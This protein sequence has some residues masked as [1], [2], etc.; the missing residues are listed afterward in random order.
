[1]PD[2]SGWVQ[3]LR[4]FSNE[5]R[6]G[7][8]AA[9]GIYFQIDVTPPLDDDKLKALEEECDG[10]LPPPLREFLNTGASSLTF[11]WFTPNANEPDFEVAFCPAEELAVWRQECI[12]YA[13]ESW[14]T[15]PEW[16]LDY[17]LWRHGW[18]LTHNEAGDGLAIW[19]H[20]RRQPHHP[21]TYLDHEGE[22]FLIAPT[23]D[24]FL[25]HWERLGYLDL[26]DLLEFRDP[27][28]G[29]LNAAVQK[30]T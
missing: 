6:V 10:Y 3:R 22:S 15:E 12:E 18:P 9:G 30:G 13:A 24:H 4:A 27:K 25:E 23:F 11:R 5:R 28:T 7:A 20:D 1:V 26:G 17:A 14:L 16:P 2:Y 29:F 19:A 21:V 8:M